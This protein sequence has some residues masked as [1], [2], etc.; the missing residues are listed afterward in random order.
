ML[1]FWGEVDKHALVLPRDIR[2]PPNSVKK[3][4]E[5]ERLIFVVGQ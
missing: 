4:M 3:T 1:F 2:P 5:H